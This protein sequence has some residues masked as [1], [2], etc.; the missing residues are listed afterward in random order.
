MATEDSAV[1][2]EAAGATREAGILEVAAS[3]VVAAAGAAREPRTAM[4]APQRKQKH[5][6]RD[7][8]VVFC[9]R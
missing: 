1:D 4:A 6:L 3:S 8:L 7:F 9:L 5:A 2:S